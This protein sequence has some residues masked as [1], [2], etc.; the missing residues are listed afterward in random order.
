VQIDLFLKLTFFRDSLIVPFMNCGTSIFAGFVTFSIL[1]FMAH[2][3]G[4][5]IDNVVTQG[6][7]SNGKS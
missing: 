3:K 6:N 2:E 1:G 4:V 5:S 7:T